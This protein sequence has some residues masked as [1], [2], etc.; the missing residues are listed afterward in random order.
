MT[1][2]TGPKIDLVGAT[3]TDITVEFK[4]LSECNTYEL[5]WKAYP[6]T[7]DLLSSKAVSTSDET[8]SKA[9]AAGLDPG[10]TYCVRMVC[11]DGTERGEP[12]AELIIDTEQVGCTPKSES[13]GCC[14]IL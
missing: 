5:Q 4:P 13:S 2:P 3:E 8:K 9:V 10:A 6:Q 1:V 14:V 11:V 12:G 7:W